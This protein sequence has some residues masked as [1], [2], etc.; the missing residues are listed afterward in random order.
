[1]GKYTSMGMDIVV[2]MGIYAALPLGLNTIIF[3]E[4]Y[5]LDG[6]YPTQTAVI[7]TLGAMITVPICMMIIM[8]LAEM[9]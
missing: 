4:D 1:M 3:A 2:T 9:V 6:T 5:G 7:S 8:K